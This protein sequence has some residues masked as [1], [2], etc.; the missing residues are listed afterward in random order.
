MQHTPGPWEILLRHDA[1]PFGISSPGTMKYDTDSLCLLPSGGQWRERIE[2]MKANARLI[3]ASPELLECCQN[4]LGAYAAL[5]MAEVSKHLPSYQE[6]L[7]DLK[8]AILKA[9]REA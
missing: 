4:A 8:S 3:A 9:T 2:E 7:N 1:V 5:D 6:C